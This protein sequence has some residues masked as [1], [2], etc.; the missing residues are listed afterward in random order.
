MGGLR[1]A[2][3]KCVKEFFFGVGGGGGGLACGYLFNFSKVTENAII[4]MKLL[5]LISHL[6]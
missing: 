6:L 5:N 4:T 2:K 1:A 3:E